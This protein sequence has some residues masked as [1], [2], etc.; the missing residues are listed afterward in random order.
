MVPVHMDQYGMSPVLSN[1]VPDTLP[2]LQPDAP[3]CSRTDVLPCPQPDVLPCAR[4]S[5]SHVPA[6]SPAHRFPCYPAVS[7]A[8][9]FPCIPPCPRFSMSPVIL[10]HDHS[11]TLFVGPTIYMITPEHEPI[12]N[13]SPHLQ[14]GPSLTIATPSIWAHVQL[15]I[16]YGQL[17]ALAVRTLRYNSATLCAGPPLPSP[18]LYSRTQRLPMACA[19]GG[20][21]TRS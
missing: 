14:V 18:D 5:I 9:R 2:R 4:L 1:H 8:H 19:P 10:L 13:P 11:D 20:R 15:V 12:P 16:H 17:S 7:P 3:L 6:V 21:E